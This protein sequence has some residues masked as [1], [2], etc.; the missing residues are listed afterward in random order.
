MS[1]IKI[2]Y[3]CIHSQYIYIIGPGHINKQPSKNVK[4]QEKSGDITCNTTQNANNITNLNE[5]TPKS[6]EEWEEMQEKC[7]D[8]LLETR[9]RP[10]F[11]ISY[12]QAV[13][14]EDVY[15]QVYFN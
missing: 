6:I 12:K 7:D 8:D 3:I 14:T 1:T 4:C 13:R 2:S 11:K 10:N 5:S 15:L 9:T